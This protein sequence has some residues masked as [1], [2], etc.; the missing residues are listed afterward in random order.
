MFTGIIE[1]T[2][3]IMQIGPLGNGADDGLHLS[4]FSDSLDM[5]DIS[6]GDSIAVNGVCLTVTTLH[7]SLFTVDVSSETLQCTC[8][9]NVIDQT[10]N[11][12]KALRLSDR[13]GGHLVSGHVDTTG[14]VIKFELSKENGENYLLTIRSPRSLLRYITS[15]GSITINGVSL[16]V[17]RIE[18]D[19]FSINLIPHTVSVTTLSELKSGM[20]VNLETDMLARYVERLLTVPENLKR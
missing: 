19:T 13:L 14:E 9:L 1:T 11:L 5:S 12:E 17:N 16:T 4:I 6:I 15:K 3:K 20:R 8:G 10:V 7:D 2:G 18:D